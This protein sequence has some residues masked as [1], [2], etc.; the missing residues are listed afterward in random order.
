MGGH[1]QRGAAEERGREPGGDEKV[2][3]DD[4]RLRG[5]PDLLREP[6]VALLATAPALR[7][8]A[9]DLMAAIDQRPLDPLDERAQ[10][11]VARP[12]IHL[13]DEEDLQERPIR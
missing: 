6:Q 13:R 10:V 11:R 3:V 1:D 9:L 2:R 12:G 7:H 4:V 8:D 5:T